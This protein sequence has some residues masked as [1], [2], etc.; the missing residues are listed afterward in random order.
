[1]QTYTE[2]SPSGTGLRC[3]VRGDL[4]GP[5]KHKVT[6]LGPDRHGV[7][8]VYEEN[9]YLTITGDIYSEGADPGDTNPDES[10]RIRLVDDPPKAALTPERMAIQR[11]VAIG[12]QTPKAVGGSL[13]KPRDAIRKTMARMV[14]AGQLNQSDYG[15]FALV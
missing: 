11:A 5:Y 14:E 9:R 12:H 3:L 1:M 8:E 13:G 4:P 15:K 10:W 7:L 6:G 2:Y